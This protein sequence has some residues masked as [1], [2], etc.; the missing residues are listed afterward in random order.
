MEKRHK[1]LPPV[2]QESQTNVSGIPL[3]SGR[4]DTIFK[5]I[6]LDVG[7]MHAM[8]NIYPETV[9]AKDLNAIFKW[10]VAEQFAGQE[11]L[12][13]QSPFS[14]IELFYWGRKA[15]NSTAEIDYLVDID[16]RIVPVE[17]KSGP[18]GHMKSMFMYIEKYTCE[19]AYRISQA[20]FKIEGPLTSIPFY[21]MEAF[22]KRHD[23]V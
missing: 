23:W 18:K 8:N 11:I 22:F 12:A 20:P 15:R 1:P 2:A 9:R 17:I 6:F 7:L 14:R 5:V 21:A 19:T 16:S 13:T 4:H 10:G 3:S